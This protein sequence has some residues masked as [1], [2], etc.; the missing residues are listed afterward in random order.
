MVFLKN[1]LQR[2]ADDVRLRS[3]NELGVFLKFRLGTLLDADL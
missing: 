1:D 3:V 2:F